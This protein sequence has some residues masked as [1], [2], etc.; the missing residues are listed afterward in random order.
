[1]AKHNKAGEKVKKAPG[2]G[3]VKMG[4][5]LSIKNRASKTAVGI[6]DKA[7]VRRLNMYKTAGPKRNRDGKIV[8]AAEF[9]HA[10]KSGERARI[11]P[12]RKWFGNT[13]TLTQSA[14]QKFQVEMGKI[15]KSPYQVIMKSSKVPTGLLQETAKTVNVHILKTESFESTF[16]PN[17]HRKRPKLN[18]ENIN[19]MVSKVD[20]VTTKHTEKE[21]NKVPELEGKDAPNDYIFG[22]GMSRRI[23]AELFKVIDSSDVVCQVL[24]ARDP[25]GTR[26]KYVEHYLRTEKAHKHLIFILNKCDLVPT[27]VTK[28]WLVHL[29]AEYPTLAFHASITKSFGKGALINLLRQFS[30]L[31]SDKKQISVGFIGYPNTGKSSIINTLKQKKCCK[32]APLAGETKVWQYVTL[33]RRVNL[34]DCPGVV[35]NTSDTNADKICKGVVRLE[36]VTNI[37]D[38]IE[39]VMERV[40]PKYLTQAYKI[41]KWTDGKD[42]LAQLCKRTGKLLKRGEPNLD[43]MARCVFHDFQRGRLPYFQ[44]PPNAKKLVVEPNTT[45]PTETEL[46]QL[47]TVPDAVEEEADTSLQ[48]D[49]GK[50]PETRPAKKR[51]IVLD[52]D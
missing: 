31:H 49:E 33:F 41:E 5:S 7:T 12:N 43:A 20:E 13:R 26:S 14:L 39:S 11:E 40:Q 24:D 17:K 45:L 23:H 38:Y 15:K 44:A 37:C 18:V 50:S 51:K 34:I 28:G 36:Y 16:G 8:E 48:T 29:S 1:M 2:P 27:W 19:D 47:N 4:H 21:E 25:M 9:Q 30:K 46:E 35:N 42:F 32:V 6:R 52:E 10:A 3:K 22:A